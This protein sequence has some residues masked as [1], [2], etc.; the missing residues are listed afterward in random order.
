M[1]DAAPQSMR[2]ALW[3]M[4]LRGKPS[5]AEVAVA[6]RDEPVGEFTVWAMTLD[7]MPTTNEILARWPVS[8]V[9]ARHWRISLARLLSERELPRMAS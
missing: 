1:N 2:L 7:H 4:T 3:A 6:F 9:A 5:P 8:K